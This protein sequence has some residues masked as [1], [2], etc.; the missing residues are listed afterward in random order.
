MDKLHGDSG[1]LQVFVHDPVIINISI[2]DLDDGKK[3]D[4][5]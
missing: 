3:E 5:Y 4:A 1:V 2:Y